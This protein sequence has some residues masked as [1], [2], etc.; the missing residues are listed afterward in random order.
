MIQPR[1]VR[2]LGNALA[3][4]LG[5]PERG[6]VAFLRCLPSA[7]VEALATSSDFQVPT[8]KLF[9]VMDRADMQRRVITAD[10]AVELREDKDDPILLLIDTERAGAGLDGIYSAGREI[11]EREL[12]IN[13]TELARKDLRRGQGGF[14]R[15]AVTI[16]RRIGQRNLITPWQEVDF[17]V[18]AAA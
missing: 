4:L 18:A 7:I 5:Q 3:E 9:G 2:L 14:S 13:A 1:H 15:T 11:A 6:T 16:A 8:F 12:F 17:L 10:Q